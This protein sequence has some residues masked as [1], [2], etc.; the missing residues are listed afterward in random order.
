MDKR[1]MKKEIMIDLAMLTWDNPL[2]SIKTLHLLKYKTVQ[3]WLR[4]KYKIRT[5]AQKERF[6]QV[7]WEVQNTL[8]R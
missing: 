5:K 7:L 4:D 6:E 1:Q 2:Y 8:G 3:D